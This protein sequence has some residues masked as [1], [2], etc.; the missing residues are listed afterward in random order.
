MVANLFKGMVL[1]VEP[2]KKEGKFLNK[3]IYFNTLGT[4]SLIA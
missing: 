1:K 2:N 3:F 4:A